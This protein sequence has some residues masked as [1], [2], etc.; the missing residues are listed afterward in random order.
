MASLEPERCASKLCLYVWGYHA[1]FVDDPATKRLIAKME[2][3]KQ[4]L[5]PEVVLATRQA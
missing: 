4:K 1:F 5:R 2:T 3:T